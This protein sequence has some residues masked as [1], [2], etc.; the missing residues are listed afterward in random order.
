MSITL[1]FD[2]PVQK[3]TFLH[4]AIFRHQARHSDLVDANKKLGRSLQ[5][6]IKEEQEKLVA[7]EEK[8]KHSSQVSL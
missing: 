1:I 2:T 4:P 5:K 6:L 8:G 3:D 7:L